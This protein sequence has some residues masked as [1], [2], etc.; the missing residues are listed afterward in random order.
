MK[1]YSEQAE[2]YTGKPWFETGRIKRWF[3]LFLSLV[4]VCSGLWLN[5]GSA[6]AE[7]F[8]TVAEFDLKQLDGLKTEEGQ[9]VPSFSLKDLKGH[10]TVVNVFASWCVNCRQE[11]ES[12]MKLSQETG[13]RL[14]GLNY[15]DRPS[16]A[17]KMLKKH[18]NPYQS[19]GTDEDGRIGSLFGVFAVPETYIIDANGKI[20]YKHIGP[21]RLNHLDD[22]KKQIIS[23]EDSISGE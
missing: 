8:K 11:H 22:F 6:S 21:I 4:G 19:I 17:L 13:I 1:F 10:V 12:L 16:A 20:R 15:K 23:A 5:M 14:F 9:E 18:G 3:Y 7:E 2:S